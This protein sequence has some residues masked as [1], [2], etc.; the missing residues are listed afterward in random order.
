MFWSVRFWLVIRYYKNGAYHH[1]WQLTAQLKCLVCSVWPIST[2]SSAV[3]CEGRR[4]TSPESTSMYLILIIFFLRIFLSYYLQ[5]RF[6]GK[7]IECFSSKHHNIHQQSK[8]HSKTTW[9]FVFTAEFCKPVHNFIIG[10][11]DRTFLFCSFLHLSNAGLWAFFF[12]LNHF[13][14]WSYK[15][16][17]V[18]MLR[19]GRY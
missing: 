12:K 17:L 1:D 16:I 9:L 18:Q 5:I 3:E 6:K 15:Q 19:T 2:V 11:L 14:C 7:H 4:I 13:G 8:H 10:G